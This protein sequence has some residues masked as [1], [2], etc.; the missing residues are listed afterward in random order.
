[1]LAVGCIFR[2]WSTLYPG[3]FCIAVATEKTINIMYLLL[4][5]DERQSNIENEVKGL[6][7]KVTESGKVIDL[8]N[9][10]IICLRSQ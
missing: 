5:T 9:D 7:E 6:R 4:F 8:I 10:E 2:F 3:K 1:M